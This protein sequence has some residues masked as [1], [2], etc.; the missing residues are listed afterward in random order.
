MKQ[1]EQT[2]GTPLAGLAV[3]VTNGFFLIG[4]SAVDADVQ[5]NMQLIKERPWFDI[6]IVYTNGGRAILA[7]EKG[8]PG[9]RAF[10]DAFAAW[11]KK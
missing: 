11:E 3:K 1:S 5:R 10:A 7:M 2:R 4:L 9:D 6:P 8:P